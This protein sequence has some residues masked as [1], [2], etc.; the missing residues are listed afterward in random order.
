MVEIP[1]VLFSARWP[2]WNRHPSYMHF[3]FQVSRIQAYVWS[4]YPIVCH[5][6][7]FA[8]LSTQEAAPPRR[9]SF[10][11]CS[12]LLP[13]DRGSLW[14]H[15][16]YLSITTLYITPVGCDGK[17]G[18]GLIVASRGTLLHFGRGIKSGGAIL[19]LTAGPRCIRARSSVRICDCAYW[20]HHARNRQKSFAQSLFELDRISER[21]YVF[22]QSNLTL[23]LWGKQFF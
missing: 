12:W 13:R 21:I 10:P 6:E 23:E 20:C 17:M 7:V 3:I 16:S 11:H 1:K 9:G 22:V 14:S 8:I 5:A 4:G 2:S 15:R 18:E 19:V